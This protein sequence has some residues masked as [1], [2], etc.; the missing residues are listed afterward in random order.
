V[1]RIALYPK[2]IKEKRARPNVIFEFGYFVG[3]LG[4]N[5]VCCLYKGD[6]SLPSDLGGLIYKKILSSV[7][8]EGFGIIKELKAAGYRLKLS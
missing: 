1:A 7:E 8:A 5:R 2:R 4:R 6:V 3:K